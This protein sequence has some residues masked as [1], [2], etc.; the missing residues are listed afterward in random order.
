[1]NASSLVVGAYTTDTLGAGLKF[2]YPLSESDA[3]NFNLGA[4]G[5]KLG[6]VD[7]SPLS[8][9]NF[10]TLF[11][12]NYSYA[13]ASVS[14][15]R[16]GRDSAIQPTRG[17]LIRAG[18]EIAGGDLQ[19]YRANLSE[20]WF[21]PLSRT[22]TLS[23]G[24]ELGYVHG[25]GGKSVPFFKNFYA[26]GPGSVRGYKAFSLGPQDAQTNV[27]GGTRKISGSAEILFPVP[28]AQQDKSLRL[29]AFVDT[30]QVYGDGQKVALGELRYS[31]GIGLAWNS[32]FGPLK[33]SFA[34]PL[35]A[36]KSLDRVERLQFNFGTSF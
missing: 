25:L 1:V 5:V 36:K 35:N 16:E 20:Q 29:A 23:L 15:G 13:T 33:L 21:Y 26:G 24:G 27:L 9:R 30:G 17:A 12:S 34:Q 19:Y 3:I 11:G 10:A 18:L 6:L 7:T 14:W 32:P 28:G 31:A 2:G 4:E 8:Y 22:V